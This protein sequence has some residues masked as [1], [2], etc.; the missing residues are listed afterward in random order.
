MRILHFSTSDG[1]GGAGR[2][3]YRLHSA[4]RKAGNDSAMLVRRRAFDHERS[5]DLGIQ[6]DADDRDV[7]VVPTSLLVTQLRR[8]QR[9]LPVVRAPRSKFTFNYDLSQGIRWQRVLAS[10]AHPPDAVCLHWVA[11]FLTSQAIRLIHDHFR[12]PLL[13]TVMDQEPVTGGCHYS[14][15][16]HGYQHECGNCPLL[17]RPSTCDR[18]RQV[19][20]RKQRHLAAL[21][22]TFVAPTSWVEERVR[23][24][25]LFGR[26]RVERIALP[27]DTAIFRPGDRHEARASLGIPPDR[28]V[29]F[30]GS[31]FLHEPRKGGTFLIDALCRAKGAFD[32]SPHRQQRENGE[33]RPVEAADV[34]LLIA[35][36]NGTDLKH[37]LPFP[38][39]DLGYLGDEHRLATAY[40]AADAFV[41]P[42]IEDAGPMMI[43]EAMLCGT[44]VV[45]FNTGGA[46]DLVV[47]GRTGFLAQLGDAA[48]LAQGLVHVLSSQGLANMSETAAQ[49]ARLLHEPAL[50]ARRYATLVTEQAEANRGAAIKNR[51]A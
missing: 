30:F 16:C 13:W 21:P 51:A 1:P 26:H 32:R 10:V 19:F 25:A 23:K 48:E 38:V 35:G 17:E 50:V 39:H 42:S 8:L 37:R 14:F 3:A 41:C 33:Y 12:C 46:P 15:G 7:R 27:I 18:S 6:C 49:S 22:I 45:A 28:R 5:A 31:S 44:P 20:Q 34:L 43:P 2:A 40:R 11:E 47:S 29:V 9:H 36:H 4:L 24:S